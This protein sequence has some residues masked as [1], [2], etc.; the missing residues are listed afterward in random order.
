[1][2]KTITFLTF[3]I[4]IAIAIAATPGRSSS[5]A[6]ASHT[7]APNEKTCAT[8][9]CHDDNP[10]NNG[11]ASLSLE[12]G[13]GIT[14]YVAGHTYPIK[15]R[16]SDDKKQRFGFQ[17]LALNAE[18]KVNLGSFTIADSIRTQLV[19]N[20]YELKE[21]EY[22]TYT[23][24]GTDAVKSGVGEWIVNWTAPKNSSEPVTFYVGAVSANDD[25]SDKGDK[26]Y[27]K[28]LTL[29]K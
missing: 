16:I 11:T 8:S 9:G 26:V 25:M 24:N 17:I 18:T 27:T 12:I 21:R 1:M 19:K 7:G 14:K 3:G 20:E 22:V 28:S 13:N 4:A 2:K 6:P 10:I 29:N 15:I 5:G 23:F